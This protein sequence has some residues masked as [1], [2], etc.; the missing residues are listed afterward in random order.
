MK[1]APTLR[2]LVDQ[3]RRRPRRR[4]ACSGCSLRMQ[5]PPGI[6]A[7]GL[8]PS[9]AIS[10]RLRSISLVTVNSSFMIG[11]GPFSR[12]SSSA[13]SQPA[14]AISRDTSSVNCTDSGEPYFMP[15]QRHGAAE[16]E[17]AHAVAA[18]AHDLVALLLERQAVDLDHVVEHAREHLHHFAVFV[19]SRIRALGERIA[20]EACEIDRAQQAGAVR[21]ERLFA[22]LA[23]HQAVEDH[24]C[25]DRPGSYRTPPQSDVLISAMR[26]H[27]ALR[28]AFSA[29]PCIPVVGTSAFFSSARKPISCHERSRDSPSMMQLVVRLARI[30]RACHPCR[31]AEAAL[32][33]R[34]A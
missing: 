19:S 20:H 24:E 18:L 5:H 16:P 8:Q 14:S 22:A 29:L 2:Q 23:R 4:A 25:S 9:R 28:F 6:L 1:R 11:A 33:P 10:G 34:G 21:R 31:R 15:Q 26:A 27:E 32:P 13:A 12:A 7:P 3:L 30:L 17:E